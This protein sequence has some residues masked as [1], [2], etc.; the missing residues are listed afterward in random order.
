MANP[1]HLELLQESIEAW[2]QWREETPEEQ[3]DLSKANLSK[4]NLSEANLSNANLSEANLNGANL[5]KAYLFEANLR[6]V[7]FRGADLSGADLRKA[8]LG[9]ADLRGANLSGTHLGEAYLRG[10]DFSRTNLTGADLRGAYLSEAILPRVDLNRVDLSRVDLS[11][12][13]L[14]RADLT[15]TNLIEADLTEANFR[16]ANLTKANLTKANLTRVSLKEADL[17]ET[18]FEG[19]VLIGAQYTHKYTRKN[20]GRFGQTRVETCF[21]NP[22]F[23]KFAQDQVYLDEFRKI[24]PLWFE[25]WWKSSKCGQSLGRI[26]LWLLLFSGLFG[27]TYAQYELPE[28]WL[29]YFSWFELPQG[30]SFVYNMYSPAFH[31]LSS[32]TWFTPYYFSMITLSTFGAGAVTPVNLAG[33][34]WVIA[35]V[36]LGYILLGFLI[37]VFVQKIARRS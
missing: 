1:E 15:E 10:A 14:S 2:N 35:E 37:S 31:N 9:R 24:H 21:G 6:I 36:L 16:G 20:I 12:A 8:Q 34:I 19:T 3:P 30:L 18:N 32:Y 4:T 28:G 22:L 33:E 26:V 7:D 29:S 5:S 13:D 27:I 11:R 25:V 17:R 23:K